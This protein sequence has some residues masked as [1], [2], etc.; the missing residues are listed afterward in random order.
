MSGNKLFLRRFIG[1]C[2]YQWQVIHTVLDWS[3]MLYIAIPTVAIIPFLYADVWRNIRFYWDARIP[4]SIVLIL[5]L[6]LSGSGNIRTYLFDA[7][8]LFLIQK[9]KVIDQLKRD[10][11]LNSLLFLFLIE[12]I[13]MLA[14]LPIL[15]GI[16]RFTVLQAFSMFWII[17][18]FKLTTM[19]IKKSVDHAI[20]RWLL[21]FIS[22]SA[23]G[24]LL[25]N[26]SFLL[27]TVFGVIIW[28]LMLWLNVRQ[29]SKINLWIKDLETEYD[30]HT[31]LIRLILR[32]TNEVPKQQTK[33][34]GKPVLFF[35]K[36]GRIF[37]Q[38]SEENG[39]L[40]FLLKSVF[41]NKTRLS[42]YYKLIG[43]TCL[44]VLFLPLGLKWAVYV[45][46]IG[47]INKWLGTLFRD[48][49]VD[50]FFVLVPYQS[51][52][53]EQACLRFQKWLSIPPDI[54]VGLITVVSTMVILGS[55]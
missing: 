52:S 50:D 24:I 23:A 45:L 18:A 36:S 34:S 5:L 9:R 29:F 39:L 46:F 3:V 4:F 30:A 53:A 15:V 54:L 11:F 27:W 42:L 16:Y 48:M 49:T 19:T 44:A 43:V 31:R 6:V 13:L 8:L 40:E 33:N 1:E 12:C 14:V 41:R 20:I 10:G 22:F 47:F 2:R 28:V 21:R 7:D 37:K 35:R 51:E 25:I 55:R 26:A 32:Y 17:S 38:R